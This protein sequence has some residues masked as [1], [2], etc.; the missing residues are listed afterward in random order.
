M[1]NLR[2][3]ILDHALEVEKD[4]NE[5]SSKGDKKIRERHEIVLTATRKKEN[6]R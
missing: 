5:T 4:N 2:D 1:A 6:E 3:Q